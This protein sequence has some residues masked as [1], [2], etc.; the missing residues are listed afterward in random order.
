VTAH[1]V[2]SMPQAPR[3]TA[4]RRSKTPRLAFGPELLLCGLRLTGR[5]VVTL[6]WHK[7][8]RQEWL[9]HDALPVYSPGT[10]ADAKECL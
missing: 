9:L 6:S 10:L 1:G 7:I 2:T 8:Q 5:L 4:L 3:Y